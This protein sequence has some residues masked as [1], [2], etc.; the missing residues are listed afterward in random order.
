MFLVMVI[1]D[2]R[3]TFSGRQRI[4][5]VDFFRFNLPFRF[6]CFRSGYHGEKTYIFSLYVLVVCLS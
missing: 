5:A 3:I 4:T 2:V 6:A 1:T